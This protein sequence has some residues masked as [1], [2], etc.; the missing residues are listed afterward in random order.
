MSYITNFNQ[1]VVADTNNSYS[2]NIVVGVPFVGSATSSLGVAGIQVSLKTD[3]NC[4]VYVEQA[5]DTSLHN[6]KGT[7]SAN[8]ST[9]L[10]G[11][12]TE[13]TRELHIGD[14]IVFDSGGTPQTKTVTEIASDTSLTVDTAFTGGSLSGKTYQH[15]AWDISDEYEYLA[16]QNNFGVT[17]QAVNSYVRVRVIN[18]GSATTSYFRLQTAL[19]P[20]VEAMPRALDEHG[21]LKVKI[22]HISDEY[23]FE[24]E[25]TPIGEM[26]VAE[27]TR[28]AGTNFD[29][30]GNSGAVDNNFW[31]PV[32]SNNGTI[33]QSAGE[34]ILS[35]NTTSPNGTAILHSV[36][37][38]RYV[39]GSSMCY[40]A[41][42]ALSAGAT[43][44]KRRWGVGWGSSMPTITDGAWF[45]LDGTEFSVNTQL[46]NGAVNKVTIF[47][48]E[49][50]ATYTPST[51]IA[52]Y[53]IYWTNSSVWFV[54]G[55]I[56]LHKVSASSDKWSSTMSPYIYFDNVNSNNIQTDH[57][58]KCRV[59]SIRR[60]GSLLTQPSSYYQ[61]LGQ[62]GATL[63]FG[64][65]NVHSV[66][67]SRA[68][69]NAVITLSDST[70][71]TTPV[72]WAMT[73]GAAINAPISIDLKGMPFFD[74]LRLTTSGANSE[75]TVI[76]E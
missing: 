51:D 33:V 9:T 28:L 27:P 66:V 67:I 12:G 49:L 18:T 22:E 7:V 69:N 17:V 20:I 2:S 11:S 6:G 43:N 71:T 34:V 5:P 35:T 64:A 63:K 59:A 45:Q 74:G 46:A 1:N 56:V 65:G 60:L 26:R 58:L 4:L 30:N 29:L 19:C 73:A 16:S 36:R 14:T 37:R 48:G 57:T 50:G 68:V 55:G 38:S 31:T 44:N 72:R 40:R 23:G 15:Y 42:V 54:I 62:A 21:H 47:N 53:E 39:S 3:Q 52:T 25:N 76:Y 10:T 8:N 70:T 41:V 61:A 13:F 24:V 75:V 32:V